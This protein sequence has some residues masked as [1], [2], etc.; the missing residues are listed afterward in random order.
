M[1]AHGQTIALAL[2]ALLAGYGAGWLHFASLARV[3]DLLAAGR[4]WA[5]W[6]QL[7]RLV[8]LGLFLYLCARGG[9]LVLLAAGAGVL[10]GRHHV[11][12]GGR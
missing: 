10:L 7:L 1:S 9:A 5:L 2:A 12:R 3:A 11:V 8:A 6:L 4:L